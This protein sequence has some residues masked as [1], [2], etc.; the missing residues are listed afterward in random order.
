MGWHDCPP[1]GILLLLMSGRCCSPLDYVARSAC[2]EAETKGAARAPEQK[3]PQTAADPGPNA[4]S[5]PYAGASC[6]AVCQG[7]QCSTL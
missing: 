6:V 3:P 1:L 5:R 2:L 4:S 7:F